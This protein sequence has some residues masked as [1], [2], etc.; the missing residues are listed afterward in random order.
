[1]VTS[2]VTVKDYAVIEQNMYSGDFK[3]ALFELESKKASLYN[4]KDVVLYSLDSG[5]LA[6]YDGNWIESN[7]NLIDAEKYMDLYYAKS[8]TQTLSSF[9]IN[10][11]LVDY[12]GEDY[13]NIYTNL[14]MALNYVHLGLYDEALVEVRRFNNKL[15]VMSLAYVD[16]IEKAKKNVANNDFHIDSTLADSTINFHNSALVRYV[17]MLLYRDTGDIGNA[18][19][20]KK[21]IDQAFLTQRQLYSF[22]K[23]SSLE[24][25]LQPFDRGLV[26]L[27]FISGTGL[28][29]KKR[30]E[31]IRFFNDDTNDYFKFEIPM[32]EKRNSFI[33]SVSVFVRNANGDLVDKTKL[34]KIE[35]IES[36]A[37]DTFKQKQALLYLKSLL[38][39]VSKTTASSAIANNVDSDVSDLIRFVSAMAVEVTEKADL[40]TSRFFPANFWV[41][42]ITLPEDVY[43]IVVNYYSA[44]GNIIETYTYNNVAVEYGRPNIM[45]SIC[46]K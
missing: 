44:S 5:L 32:M 22:S 4:E 28:A 33:T 18:Q 14:F 45:E 17:S 37:I 23:P 20:D 24:D 11:S 31:T 29:P 46:V 7:K 19:V 1:M 8:I 27:N 25:E 36:I 10:D 3:N 12:P 2:C 6:H 26:R 34:E 39:S 40:R 35:S 15:K 38:R 42:G 13:E 16:A 21:Y 9:I 30:A 43:T 41:G